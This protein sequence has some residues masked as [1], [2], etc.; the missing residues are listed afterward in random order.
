MHATPRRRTVT[1]AA[2]TAALPAG[3]FAASA[4]VAARRLPAPVP[5]LDFDGPDLTRRWKYVVFRSTRTEHYLGTETRRVPE[6][7]VTRPSATASAHPAAPA[8]P[9]TP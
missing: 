7:L 4:R 2:T 3:L 6:P 1:V 9:A 5:D 8:R